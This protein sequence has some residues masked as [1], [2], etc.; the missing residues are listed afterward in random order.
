MLG[1]KMASELRRVIKDVNY[2]GESESDSPLAISTTSPAVTDARLLS[3]D[4]SLRRLAG[5]PL[6]ST[7]PPDRVVVEKTLDEV[8]PG[9]IANTLTS[10]NSTSST[11]DLSFQTAV[12]TLE[13]YTQ[14][15]MEF[16]SLASTRICYVDAA[17]NPNTSIFIMGTA[18][19]GKVVY[20]KGLLTQ[21]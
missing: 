21:T 4:A 13:Y 19:D 17:N 7:N 3:W 10:V 1:S 14:L 16:K 5:V 18:E 12:E 2:W 8:F 15:Y 9:L 20:A 11:I 6:P